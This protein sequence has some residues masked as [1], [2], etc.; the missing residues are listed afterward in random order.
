MVGVTSDLV[1][2]LTLNGFIAAIVA[3]ATIATAAAAAV[4]M[5][6]DAFAGAAC[7]SGGLAVRL[8]GSGAFDGGSRLVVGIIV[9][10]IAAEKL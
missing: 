5:L 2:V 4:V 8:D 1:A 7:F 6:V 10:R 9:A 3:L